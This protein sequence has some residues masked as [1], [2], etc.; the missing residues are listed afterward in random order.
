ALVLRLLRPDQV[1]A[2]GVGAS[3]PV[4]RQ[5]RLGVDRAIGLRRDEVETADV[6]MGGEHRLREAR[7]TESVRVD[8]RVDVCSTLTV[9]RVLIR[10]HHLADG[11]DG[12]VAVISI[13]GT[14]DLL[15]CGEAAETAEAGDACSE[16]LDLFP[17]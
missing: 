1:N 4:P 12:G 17:G 5:I 10:H 6:A 15:G 13:A 7:R 3:T 9:H 2:A 11:T 16:C 14:R 8:G